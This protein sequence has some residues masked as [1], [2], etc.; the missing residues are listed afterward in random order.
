[1]LFDTAICECTLQ[2]TQLRTVGPTRGDDEGSPQGPVGLLGD[3]SKRF[4]NMPSQQLSDMAVGV[5]SCSSIVSPLLFEPCSGDLFKLH[6]TG[7]GPVYTGKVEA[8][9][10]SR[11]S[12][13]EAE[14]SNIT[15][16][17]AGDICMLF[18]PQLSL[19]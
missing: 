19:T 17:A 7:H 14:V 12:G 15:D 11:Y 13:A 1:M 10:R 4:L 9:V 5:K 16:V 2:I 8:D 3:S 6:Q 18:E